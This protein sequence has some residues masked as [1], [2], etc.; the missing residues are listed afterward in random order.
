MTVIDIVIIFRHNCGI[1]LSLQISSGV[2]RT[3]IHGLLI[4]GFIQRM[5]AH[6]FQ[7][8]T[9][10]DISQWRL[11][12]SGNADVHYFQHPYFAQAFSESHH[13]QHQWLVVMRDGKWIATL[14]WVLMRE[15]KFM[16]SYAT[17][18]AVVYGGPVFLPGLSQTDK[19]A[20][21]DIALEGLIKTTKSKSLY[22]QFRNFYET[23]PYAQIFTRHGFVFSERLNL[24]K[25]IPNRE[26]ALM[27]M[28][29][30]RRRQVKLSR[31]NGLVVRSA[32][33]ISEVD[34]LYDLLRKLYRKKVRKPLI[35]KT[36]LHGFFKQSA[37]GNSGTVLV[38]QYKDRIV[39]GIIAPFTPGDTIFEWYV[40][41]LDKHLKQD[42]VY[43][44][45]ALTWAAMEAGMEQ[46]CHHFDF[47]GMGIPGRPYGV[48]DFKARFGGEW[49]NYGRWMRI[50]HPRTYKSVELAYNLLRLMK[51]V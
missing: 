12:L 4:K 33:S 28:S 44:T 23:E 38:A 9:R 45:V 41:G 20:C 15:K 51:K 39:G 40:C 16:F 3:C 2:R 24:I 35:A 7:H 31:T 14:A 43:P 49:V 19:E 46:G 18:R 30:S 42:K 11:W 6:F 36:V 29:P 5:Q 37:A 48:R 1:F 8:P 26:K 27:E 21:M 50:N 13:Y 22:I 47:M 32:A 34:E 17:T 10:A 25:A